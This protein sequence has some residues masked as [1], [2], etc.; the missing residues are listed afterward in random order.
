MSLL[1][2]ALLL[3]IDATKTEADLVDTF[4]ILEVNHVHNKWGVENMAQVLAWD[5]IPSQRTHHIQWW[6][7]LRECRV[8]TEEGRA[9]WEKKRREIADKIKDWPTRKDFLDSSFYRGEFTKDDPMY[10]KYN[11]R[12][13][14][15][16]IKHGDNLIRAKYFQETYTTYDPE[17]KDRETWPV[18]ARKGLTERA[19]LNEIPAEVIIQL[20]FM[21]Q[22]QDFIGPIKR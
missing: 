19:S 1:L 11:R 18:G 4:D 5:W 3:R 8:Q 16:E 2:L 20:P 6:R 14:Y 12:T 10:P 22:L 13:G 15:W 17:R 21:D 9:A 7:S